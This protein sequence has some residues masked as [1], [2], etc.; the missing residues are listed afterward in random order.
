[1]K[2]YRIKLNYKIVDRREGDI[3]QVWANLIIQIKN[4]DGKP[5]K[6]LDEMTLSA[7]KWEQDFKKK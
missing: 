7:W 4:L 2:S 3:T 5:K 6:E 1:L